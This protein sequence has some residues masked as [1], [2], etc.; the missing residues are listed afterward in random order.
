MNILSYTDKELSEKNFYLSCLL[1]F[2]IYTFPLIISDIYYL[3]DLGR[4]I[5]GHGWDH[6]ARYLTNIIYSALTFGGLVINISPYPLIISLLFFSLSSV[7]LTRIFSIK[8]SIVSVLFCSLLM[9]S[10]F[11]IEN[12]SYKFDSLSMSISIFL[13]VYA[14][15]LTSICNIKSLLLSA[16]ILSAVMFLYEPSL[17]IFITLSISLFISNSLFQIKKVSLYK[18]TTHQVISVCLALFSWKIGSK[19]L[20]YPVRQTI[21]SSPDRVSAFKEKLSIFLDNMNVVFSDRFMVAYSLLL[22]L[23]F[24]S[25]LTLVAKLIKESNIRTYAP[26]ITVIIISLPVFII[27]IQGFSFFAMRK[28]DPFGYAPRVFIGFGASMLAI[29]VFLMKSDFISQKIKLL[30]FLMPFMYSLTLMSTYCNSFGSQMRILDIISVNLSRDLV[31]NDLVGKNMVISGKM[32][33]SN[34]LNFSGKENP[35]IFKLVQTPMH[36]EW[37]WG[38]RQLITL[39]SLPALYPSE[40]EINISNKEKCSFNVVSKNI[41]YTILVPKNGNFFVLDFDRNCK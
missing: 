27:M 6:D 17:G 14:I 9:T 4:A 36:N 22:L 32:P 21:Y 15:Y 5:D 35:I 33:N 1:V 24:I 28:T 19:I 23:S 30:A 10:P 16:I 11:Y 7:Y 18:V 20:D 34:E 29:A 3:D 13:C 31:E 37:S 25:I 38:Y 41:Y 2:F 40:D 26:I 39:Y 12:L 8:R